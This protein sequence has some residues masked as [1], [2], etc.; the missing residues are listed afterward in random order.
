MWVHESFTAY[1]ESLLVEKRW[2]KKAGQEYINGTRKLIQNDKPLLGVFDVNQ[3]GSGDMYYKGSNLLNM[4]RTIIDDDIKWRHILRGLNEK[5]YHQTVTGQQ[6]IAYI[7][8]ESGLNLTKIFDQYLRYKNIPTLEIS[9]V[10]EG[11]AMYRWIADEA[12]FD[13]PV[14]IK[15]KDGDYQFIRPTT[16]FQTI[17]LPGANKNNLEADTFNFYIG[18]MMN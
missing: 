3:E 12:G 5:F 8:L 1:S 14:R 11:K 13:M 4:I 2:G 15:T 6:I 9:F 16:N 7:N 10:Q 18:V 17:D